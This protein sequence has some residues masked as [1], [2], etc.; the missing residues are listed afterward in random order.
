MCAR[1]TPVA[2]QQTFTELARQT[3]HEL[4]AATAML[5]PL[6]HHTA[7]T[8]LFPYVAAFAAGAKLASRKAAIGV[9]VTGSVVAAGATWLDG[10]LSPDSAQ[11]PWWLT[12]TVGLPV[13]VGMSQRDRIE[14]LHSARRAAEQ[15]QRATESEAREA[16]L[17]ERGRIARE[18]HDVL[19]HS[20]SGIAL[21]LDMADALRD[22]G[23]QEKATAAIR[24]ARALAVD[25]ISET[26]R[27][28]HALVEADCGRRRRS[29]A[30]SGISARGRTLGHPPGVIRRT[31]R[32]AAGCS[33]RT[34][35]MAAYD[36]EGRVRDERGG[37]QAPLVADFWAATGACWLRRGVRS[38][39]PAVRNIAG[40]H[41]GN[42]RV[43]AAGTFR[44]NLR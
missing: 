36:V 21:Q 38:R 19:G 8:S 7:T 40:P 44:G 35:R 13:Y 14:A 25:S 29:A 5:L 23:R 10:L 15:A 22:S 9:A 28:V 3:L 6:A 39:S 37:G 33:R 32:A 24:R 42:N 34:R 20:L 27:A 41:R 1:K 11:W 2:N 30:G 18:I 12:L 43:Y 16:A 4:Q 31:S 17:I 26:R